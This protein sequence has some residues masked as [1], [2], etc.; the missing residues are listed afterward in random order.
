MRKFKYKIYRKSTV[1]KIAEEEY[2]FTNVIISYSKEEGW[3]MESD[4]LDNWICID[5][6][7]IRFG[8]TRLSNSIK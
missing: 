1:K 7:G 5:S 8:L 3:W 4:Q 6:S 2:G